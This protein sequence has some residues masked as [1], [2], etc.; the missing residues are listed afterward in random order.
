[1]TAAQQTPDPEQFRSYLRLL[2]R[3][4]L[5]PRLVPKIDTSDVVQQT[6]IKAYQGLAGFRGSTEREM[7]G[8]L[9]Q[10]LANQLAHLVRDFGRQKRDAGRELPLAQVVDESSARLEAWLAAEQSSPSEHVQRS[11][12]LLQL[13][14]GLESL[15]EDQREA[16]ELHYCHGW[17]LA[18]IAT[19]LHRT[20]PSV[21]GLVHRG[22]LKLRDQLAE[23]SG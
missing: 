21:A 15:P 5:P 16:V 14:T 12:L 19:H 9:R 11:D 8:W 3:M 2:A 13:A 17:T 4:Q 18:Q 23:T 10:I 6:L 7:A 20:P 22:L 1:M